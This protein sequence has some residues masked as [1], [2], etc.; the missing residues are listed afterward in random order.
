MSYP[1]NRANATQQQQQHTTALQPRIFTYT[2]YALVP[3]YMYVPN[4]HIYLY[5][6]SGL[7]AIPST[8][9][10]KISESV[11]C[12]KPPHLLTYGIGTVCYSCHYDVQ[13]IRVC[14]HGQQYICFCGV[15]RIDGNHP[16]D[17]DTARPFGERIVRCLKGQCISL[18][19]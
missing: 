3:I 11:I 16:G 10:S 1:A 2:A 7:C 12:A 17:D 14:I 19:Q 6:A 8:M 4:H 15:G 13:D 9:I 5:M 18:H